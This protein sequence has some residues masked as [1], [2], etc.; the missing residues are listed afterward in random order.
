MSKEN[1]D[2]KKEIA[3]AKSLVL[4][5]KSLI[6]KTGKTA[7]TGSPAASNELEELQ[8]IKAELSEIKEGLK[9]KPFNL[10][11]E[12]GKIWGYTPLEE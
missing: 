3:E 12:Q 5:A 7:G 1:D 8:A 2:M 11:E 10:K 4:K 6:P 9:P